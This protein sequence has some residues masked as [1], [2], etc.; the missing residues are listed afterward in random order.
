MMRYNWYGPGDGLW[1]IGGLLF[2]IALIVVVSVEFL[3]P[4]SGIGALIWDG[5]QTFAMA[6]LYVGLVT[7]SIVGYLIT[8][9]TEEIEHLLLPWRR[10]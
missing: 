3:N 10:R 5:W 2:L 4:K 1:M 9:A 6:Q 8:V 7:I